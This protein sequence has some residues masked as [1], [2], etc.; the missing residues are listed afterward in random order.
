[1]LRAKRYKLV[2]TGFGFELLR[3]DKLTKVGP[4]RLAVDVRAA[5]D[6][7]TSLTL[8][9]KLMAFVVADLQ[10]KT[11]VGTTTVALHRI[12]DN[13]LCHRHDERH[14]E[15]LEQARELSCRHQSHVAARHPFDLSR[16]RHGH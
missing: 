8:K 10:P 4:R 11:N 12:S 14:L 1:M 7:V 9:R 2:R 6:L 13:H 16:G 15:G 3:A 5:D